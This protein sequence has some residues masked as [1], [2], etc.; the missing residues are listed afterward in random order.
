MWEYLLVGGIIASLIHE[1]RK[2]AEREAERREE[3]R[4]RRDTPCNF[5]DGFSKEDFER[6][7]YKSGK[8]IKRLIKTRKPGKKWKATEFMNFLGRQRAWITLFL[9]DRKHLQTKMATDIFPN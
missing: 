2:S 6:I 1:G 3:D 8:H 7:A 4:R 5:V 9:V